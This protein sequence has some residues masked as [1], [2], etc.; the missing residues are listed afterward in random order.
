M[1]NDMYHQGA[2]R[3]GMYNTFWHVVLPMTIQIQCGGFP[4]STSEMIHHHGVSLSKQQAAD[5]SY[6]T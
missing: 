4:F 2:G 5:L 6:G 3:L 1:C